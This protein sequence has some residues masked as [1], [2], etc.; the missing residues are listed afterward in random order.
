MKL[1]AVPFISVNNPPTSTRPSACNASAYTG[2]FA[3]TNVSN[4]VS[5]EPSAFKRAMKLR[6]VPLTRVNKPPI[7]TRPSGC[8]TSEPTVSLAPPLV[9]LPVLKVKSTDPSRFNR[10]TRLAFAPLSTLKFPPT[11]A[12]PI[13]SGTAGLVLMP[14]A[15]TTVALELTPNVR[16]IVP[17]SL[18]CAMRSRNCPFTTLKSPAMIERSAAPPLA[19]ATAL[20]GITV[21]V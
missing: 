21:P 17:S 11:T 9:P 15:C 5:S 1:R 13:N 20:E 7:T 6:L 16:S 19:P 18:S 10:A 3:P 4:E 14:I 12:L 8:T 2:L